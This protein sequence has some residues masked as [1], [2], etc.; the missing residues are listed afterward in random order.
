MESNSHE[1]TLETYGK[2]WTETDTSKRLQLFEQC[3]SPDCVY[4]DPTSQLTG[5]EQFSG[6][7]SEFQRNVPGGAFVAT[8][9]Q[10]HHGRSLMHWNMVDGEGKVLSRGASY[11][12][13]GVDGR[14]VQM[15][16]FFEANTDASP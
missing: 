15:T 4:T 7:M 5:Y 3:L 13:Y 1:N 6:Y 16:G 14:L 10:S 11:F 9:L 8:D 2:S 12:L